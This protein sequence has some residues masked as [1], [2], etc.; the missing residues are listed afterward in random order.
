MYLTDS[1]YFDYSSLIL[2]CV[3]SINVSM[4]YGLR[5]R[6]KVRFICIAFPILFISFSI[7]DAVYFTLFGAIPGK[8]FFE[9]FVVLCACLLIFQKERNKEDLVISCVYFSSEMCACVLIGTIRC[10]ISPIKNYEM[11]EPIVRNLFIVIT[12]FLPI[13]LSKI[14]VK[15][16]VSNVNNSLFLL[17]IYNSLTVIIAF[18]GHC[19]QPDF[20]NKNAVF[21]VTIYS[22]F[23]IVNLLSFWLICRNAIWHE[24][25][26]ELLADKLS[27]ENK[28]EALNLSHRNFEEL[29]K[30]R[31]DIK[32]QYSN[33]RLML[34]EKRYDDMEK[35]LDEYEEAYLAPIFA[36]DC[37]NVDLNRILN[38]E[39]SKAKQVGIEL[40]VRVVV[41]PKLPIANSDM[42]SLLTNIIDNAIEGSTRANKTDP[43]YVDIRLGQDCYLYISVKNSVDECADRS[44]FFEKRTSKRDEVAHGYGT[45]IIKSIVEKYN[46]GMSRDVIDG[47]YVIDVM[48]DVEVATNKI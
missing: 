37:G 24:K 12:V 47:K 14:K 29:H 8:A 18:M 22:G 5:R 27:S 48:L 45:K 30:I 38:L 34:M 20:T 41:P 46:G 3:F 19:M 42:C 13:Y 15:A 17:I 7:A 33:I 43:I 16:I 31:H 4:L 35:Y 2:L 1:Y 11:I 26:L 44:V 23:I 28:I 32:N 21:A 40:S 25:N 9:N 39:Y 10:M 36:I 6:K